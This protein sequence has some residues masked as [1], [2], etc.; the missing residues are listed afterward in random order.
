[1]IGREEVKNSQRERV[2]SFLR[3]I[4]KSYYSNTSIDGP[5]EIERRE[6][7]FL[8]F[9]EIMKRHISFRDRDEMNSFL[10]REGPMHSYYSTAYYLYPWES[11]ME[12]K[13]WLKAEVVFDIDADHLE[14]ECKY[15]HDSKTCKECGRE[16]PYSAE[17]CTCG[18]KSLV[19]KVRICDNCLNKAKEETIKLIEEFLLNDFGIEKR[20]IEVYFSG[21]RGYHV[22]VVKEELMSL[23]SEERREIVDYITARGL[24]P[25]YHGLR[26]ENNVLVGPKASDPGWSGR[27]SRLVWKFLKNSKEED[28]KKILGKKRFEILLKLRESGRIDRIL[29]GFWDLFTG[30]SID[31]WCEIVRTG[32]I[33]LAGKTDEPVTTDVKRLIR[34]PES[35]HGG[36]GFRVVRVEDLDKFDP[37][38]DA[39]A[40]QGETE[41]YVKGRVSEFR[42]GEEI[43]GPYEDV[44]VELPT[45][46]AVFLLARGDAVLP[47]F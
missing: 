7:A 16:N 20:E 41:V 23:G 47:R 39:L 2:K 28:L 40:F 38:K 1:M 11:E 32:G 30:L 44:E 21:R 12:R 3:A 25:K 9:D 10:G 35:L 5:M 43:F 27:I 24:N 6:F 42:I 14:L 34:L 31:K 13:G 19:E 4:F 17:R 15:H 8:T 37:L 36:T 22:H 33:K 45:S 29:D 46:A 26:V 18:S